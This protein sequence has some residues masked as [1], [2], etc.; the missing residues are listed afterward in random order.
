MEKVATARLEARL[1]Q[2]IYNI[3]KQAA[4]MT[5]KSVTEFVV[6]SAYS[7]ATKAI[8]EHSLI[9]LAISDQHKLINALAQDYEPNEAMKRAAKR[10]QAIL[11][12]K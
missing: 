5:G 4:K 3:I 6:N 1:Q 7:E 12:G 11:Q 8:K 10:H 9:E 2:D